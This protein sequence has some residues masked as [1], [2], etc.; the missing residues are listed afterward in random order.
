MKKRLLFCLCFVLILS[1]SF[2]SAI[3]DETGCVVGEDCVLEENE[4]I[5]FLGST[6]S[7]LHI[8][9]EGVNLILMVK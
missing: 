1:L 6:I 2:V 5:N 3:K 7:I 9:E 8:S 4:L